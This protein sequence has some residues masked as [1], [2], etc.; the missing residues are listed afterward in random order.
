MMLVSM[1]TA[2]RKLEQW[3][4]PAMAPGLYPVC[5][6]A[7][8]VR[9]QDI[10]PV[11]FLYEE[12]DQFFYHGVHLAPI[13]GTSFFDL[14]S[15]LGYGGAVS[16]TDNRLFLARAWRAYE[17]FCR[18][19]LVLAEFIRFHP[20]MNNWKYYN[21]KVHYNRETVWIDL[22]AGNPLD[23]Y[24]GRART[25][26]RKAMK[27]GL[28]VEWWSKEQ[29]IRVF[30]GMYNELMRE[31]QADPI[32][33]L[34][35][36]YFEFL[37]NWEQAHMA[38]CLL[39]GQVQAAAI[40]LQQ[41][42]LLEYHLSASTSQGKKWNANQL[43]I[44]EAVLM[45]QGRGCRV[46]HLG[47]GSDNHPNNPLFFFK[48]GFSPHRTGYRIGTRICLKNEYDR[49]QREHQAGHHSLPKKFLFYR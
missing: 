3:T 5:V 35:V 44:H 9:D 49:L 25:A 24:R 43:I 37:L 15:P 27:N 38:V 17:D 32:Y 31:L 2:R 13:K 36:D 16:T 12:N 11:F 39:D 6:A 28:R 1:D 30:P 18:Q 46:L 26:V 23:S 41:D 45:G 19:N 22:T 4:G 40:F 47:G 10:I 42:T 34:P 48:A 7:D 8:A 14:Q 21:G 20:L 29:F 33:F